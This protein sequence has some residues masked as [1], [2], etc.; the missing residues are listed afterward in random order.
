VQRDR[1]HHPRRRRPADRLAI[2]VEASAKV[3]HRDFAD[4][5]I[6]VPADARLKSR[7]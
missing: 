5:V 6:T 7:V 1:P 2:D 3:T 4:L